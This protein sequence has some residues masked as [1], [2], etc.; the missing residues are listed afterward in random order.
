MTRIVVI[1]ATLLGGAAFGAAD[2]APTA[3]PSSGKHRAKK[4]K[5]AGPKASDACTGDADCALTAFADGDCC[6]SLCPGRAVSKRSA[7]VLAK[8]GAECT[9]PATG[10][11]VPECMPQSLTVACEA[12]HCVKRQA[13]RE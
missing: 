10:C 9:K 11:V 6:P 13:S 5:H 12:G 2:E 8:Y 3:K 4:A 7:E 1:W